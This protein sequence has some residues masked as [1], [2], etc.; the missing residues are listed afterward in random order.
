MRHLH[1]TLLEFIRNTHKPSK[2]EELI[3]GIKL[4]WATVTP[5]K[6]RKYISHLR[7]VVPAVMDVQGAASGM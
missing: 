4:F 2:K 3:Q 7:K 5:D 1:I 6:C